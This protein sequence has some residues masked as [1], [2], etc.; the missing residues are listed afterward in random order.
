MGK[1]SGS[2][3]RKPARIQRR[4]RTPFRVAVISIAL[5]VLAGLFLLYGPLPDLRV[6]L[7]TTSMH[8]SE[9]R[10]IARML[11][12]P[13]T[14]ARILQE[15]RVI[16]PGLNTQP[17]G[18]AAT[19]DPGFERIAIR[20]GSVT[21]LLLRVKDPSRVSL[22]LSSTEEG[23]LLEDIARDAGAIGAI[24]ASGYRDI[25]KQGIPEGLVISGSSLLH[26]NERTSHSL[27]GFD[28]NHRLVLGRYSDAQLSGLRLRDAVEF[29]GPF[30]IVDGREAQIL[31][32]GGGLAPRTAIGQ[33]ADGEVL[34][35]VLDG[36]QVDTLGASMRDVLEIL[37][38]QGAVNA[39]NLDGGSSVS[40]WFEDAIINAVVQDDLHRRLPCAFIVR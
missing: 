1:A 19:G 4:R 37:R 23:Q 13:A 31:G 24:N 29:D 11:Y 9:H 12:S 40:M 2:G 16:D 3:Q 34:L 22:A 7:I 17:T 36:R 26:K 20:H 14:I 28:D 8:T 15:N 33:T 27:I 5:L 32:N 10:Y 38:E 30:L 21:G 6:F 25:H 39:A 18:A 35:L